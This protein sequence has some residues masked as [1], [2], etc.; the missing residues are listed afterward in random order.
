MESFAVVFAPECFTQIGKPC[1]ST[2]TDNT[3]QKYHT[4]RVATFHLNLV[5]AEWFM[6]FV[7]N[8]SVFKLNSCITDSFYFLLLRSSEILIRSWRKIL[9]PLVDS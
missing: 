2:V 3:L 4:V 5:M 6:L 9:G 8:Q 1:F 7:I